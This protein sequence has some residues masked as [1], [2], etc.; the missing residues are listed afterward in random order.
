MADSTHS[1][2]PPRATAVVFSP[3]L[4]AVAPQCPCGLSGP[5]SGWG[6]HPMVPWS[7]RSSGDPHRCAEEMGEGNGDSQGVLPPLVPRFAPCLPCAG[8]GDRWA[9]VSPTGDAHRGVQRAASGPLSASHTWDSI[10]SAPLLW[11]RD[12][13]GLGREGGQRFCRTRWAGAPGLSAH[14]WS[15]VGGNGGPSPLCR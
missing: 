3:S 6:S 2:V 10:V 5:L 4:R 13:P 15:L 11:S 14:M 12:L 9:G 1:W 8:S 7:W